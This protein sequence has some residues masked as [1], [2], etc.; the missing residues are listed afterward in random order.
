MRTH[1]KYDLTLWR[2]DWRHRGRTSFTSV[3]SQRA[4][5]RAPYGT[6]RPLEKEVVNVESEVHIEIPWLLHV[7]PSLSVSFWPFSLKKKKIHLSA[8]VP[9]LF[10]SFFSCLHP[11]QPPPFLLT[12]TLLYFLLPH[13]HSFLS[14]IPSYTLCPLTLNHRWTKQ[15]AMSHSIKTNNPVMGGGLCGAGAAVTRQCARWVQAAANLRPRW[16]NSQMDI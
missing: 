3:I 1:T 10:L 2:G 6:G 14:P 16:F 12:P 11:P 8:L 9:I 13:L 5:G 7:F 4:S 15:W